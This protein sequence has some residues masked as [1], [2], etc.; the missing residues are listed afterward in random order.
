ML[1]MTTPLILQ[2]VY[3]VHVSNIYMHVI[4]LVC[5]IYVPVQFAGVRLSRETQMIV[6]PMLSCTW[7]LL[8]HISFDSSI[9]FVEDKY[10]WK[11]E[12]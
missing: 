2:K 1:C 8:Y 4:L 6:F 5:Q 3:F 9:C 12:F 11:L 7:I 10:Y